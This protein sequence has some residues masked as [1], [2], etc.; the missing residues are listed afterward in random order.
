MKKLTSSIVLVL[1]VQQVVCQIT[2]DKNDILKPSKSY[3][4]KTVPDSA[5]Y[6]LWYFNIGQ[7]GADQRYNMQILDSMPTAENKVTI[8]NPKK[9]GFGEKFS[10]AN[11]MLYKQGSYFI[12]REPVTIT[13]SDFPKAG[14]SFV[15]AQ[16]DT[17][18]W[19]WDYT[20]RWIDHDRH[21]KNQY[22]NLRRSF[23]YDSDTTIEK[24]LRV[25][26]TPWPN[27][28]KQ[29]DCA[30]IA[31]QSFDKDQ[32]LRYRII[33]FCKTIDSNFVRIGVGAEVDQG[34]LAF[35]APSGTYKRTT[36][37]FERPQIIRKSGLK[38]G[39]HHSEIAVWKTKVTEAFTTLRHFDYTVDTY[40][41]TGYGTFILQHDSFQAYQVKRQVKQYW[42]DSIKSPFGNQ[43]FVDSNIVFSYEFYSKKYGLPIAV[44][45]T[46]SSGHEI[47]AAKYITTNNLHPF[48]PTVIDTFVKWYDLLEITENEVKTVGQTIVVDTNVFSRYGDGPSGVYDSLNSAYSK[49]IVYQSTDFEFGMNSTDSTQYVFSYIDYG[50]LY[51]DSVWKSRNINFDGYG[52]LIMQNDSVE[53]LRAWV[54]NTDRIKAYNF[55]GDTLHDID[56]W[57]ERNLELWYLAKNAQYPLVRVLFWGGDSTDIRRIEFME[58]PWPAN[59]SEAQSS[60]FQFDIFPNPATE[61]IQITTNTLVNK[62]ASIYNLNGKLLIESNFLDQTQLNTS[63]LTS[64]VYLLKIQDKKGNLLGIEKLVKN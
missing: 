58:M 36:Q 32:N 7:E 34:L 35:G 10:G 40:R 8:Q 23:L 60:S 42:I 25:E 61:I 22:Y 49:A 39:Q 48:N 20:K 64:G 56:L 57:I 17:S 3:K 55:R 59:I 52:T 50:Y 16:I 1:L 43:V 46:D 11:G 45:E 33:E 44:F 53:V 15:Y 5:W 51:I 54:T 9:H 62:K 47:L 14:D 26:D 30:R 4:V 2:L 29:A 28:F 18:G 63:T 41:V 37:K 31:Y 12:T 38:I 21:G 6:W 24:Y 27:E 19:Y 13:T